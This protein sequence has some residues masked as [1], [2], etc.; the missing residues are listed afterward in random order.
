MTL[1]EKIQ[2]LRKQNGMS[3]EQLSALTAVSRQAISKWEVGESIP[4][5]DNIV[6]LSEIFGVTTD[7]LLK[8]GTGGIVAPIKEET[9][10]PAP[11]PV[12]VSTANS[13]KKIG[14]T[15]VVTGLISTA[16]AATHGLLW[17]N[18]SDLLFPTA[19]VIAAIGAIILFMQSAGKTQVPIISAFGARLAAV[20]LIVICIAGIPGVLRRNH[21]D[22]LLALAFAAVWAGTGIIIAGYVAPY[23]KGRRK[24]ADVQDL[25]PGS[26]TSTEGRPVN[27]KTRHTVDDAAGN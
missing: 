17:R 3:Q 20:G 23:L 6:Q 13:P 8:N 25:R 1:G 21:A 26:K 14:T 19:L 16:I 2:I 12:P 10:L 15:M 11:G 5:V 4:D 27:G 18:T 22:I 7:Y 24:I 9:P